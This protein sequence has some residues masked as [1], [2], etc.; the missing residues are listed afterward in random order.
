MKISLITAT[1]NSADTLQSCFESVASQDYKAVE[2]IVVD[3]AS[4]DHTIQVIEDTAKSQPGFRFVSEPDKGIYDALNKG[5]A[6]ATGEVIGFLHS[7]DLLA[8]PDILTKIAQKFNEKG[9]D[10]VYA[11]LQYVNKERPDKVIR[12][13]RS[14]P[15]SPRLLNQGWMPPHPTFFLRKEVYQKHGGFD[16]T[17]KIAADYDFML[18]VLKDAGYRFSYL[19]EVV[20]K[21][22]V[23]GASNRSIRNIL[24]KSREDL[25]AMRV[26]G[27]R[28]PIT[29]LAW[30]N[31]SKLPQF[32]T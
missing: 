5:I 6:M 26:H 24:Q 23:G 10:G 27:L 31:L 16:L 12:H 28:S 7:D 4:K 15:F 21:M 2:H 18:R 14:C 32:F 30:K 22:R 13:W 9:V 1:F 20:T 29:A 25:R 8:A 3:G 11:D 17:Y 19:P